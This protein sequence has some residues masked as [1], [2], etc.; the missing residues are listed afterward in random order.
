MVASLE[1]ICRRGGTA[2]VKLSQRA[3]PAPAPGNARW[4]RGPG[5][6]H[7]EIGDVLVAQG[8]LPEALKSHHDSLAIADRLARADSGNADWQRDLSLSR[9]RIADTLLK[10]GAARRSASA[11]RAHPGPA[12]RRH[13]PDAGRSAPVARPAPRRRPAPPRRRHAVGRWPRRPSSSSREQERQVPAASDNRFW[14]K[15]SGFPAKSEIQ[16]NTEHNRPIKSM[17]CDFVLRTEN[18]L[19]ERII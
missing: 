2:T 1:A 10:L 14:C 5:E 11:G 18:R 4:Q 19:R 9:G 6:V 13:R 12:P 7:V 3:W 15:L 8:N 16:G 17:Y